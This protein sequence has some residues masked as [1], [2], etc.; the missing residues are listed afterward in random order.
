MDIPRRDRIDQMTPAELAIRAAVEAVERVGAHPLLTDAVNLLHEAQGR[1]AD[2]VDTTAEPKP[3]PQPDRPL[4]LPWRLE[5]DGTL[6]SVMSVDGQHVADDLREADAR[7]IVER[8]GREEQPSGW[9]DGTRRTH[10]EQ[11]AKLLLELEE[12]WREIEDCSGPFYDAVTSWC[13]QE[14]NGTQAK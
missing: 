7:R 12:N 4:P 5:F 2:Y 1:V 3:E 10:L 6:W 9:P 11:A 8:C 14:R 13:F